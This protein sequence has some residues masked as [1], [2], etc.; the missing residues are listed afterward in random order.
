[1]LAHLEF[2]NRGANKA[3]A[4]K[5]AVSY[6]ATPRRI[7]TM[8]YNLEESTSNYNEDSV[9]KNVH[10]DVVDEL[11]QLEMSAF[12]PELKMKS[13][14]PKSLSLPMF[15]RPVHDDMVRDKAIAAVMNATSPL[16]G[17][18]EDNDRTYSIPIVEPKT[19]KLSKGNHIKYEKYRNN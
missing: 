19:R 11:S 5:T 3:E 7:Q 9:N 13:N 6:R 1:M 2:T 4:T 15:I 14:M 17:S 18:N 10:E 8:A 12:V 16:V